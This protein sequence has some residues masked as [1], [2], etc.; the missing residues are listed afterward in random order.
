MANNKRVKRPPKPQRVVE[1]M[2]A[3]P[4]LWAS[5]PDRWP[6]IVT[7]LPD[8][9]EIDMAPASV[10]Y[11]R[12]LRGAAS[13]CFHAAPI[14]VFYQ[15]DRRA[16]QQW[17]SKAQLILDAARGAAMP[18]RWHK[19][20]LRRPPNVTD[21]RRPGYSHMLAFSRRPVPYVP[22]PDVVGPSGMVYEN[23][24]DV[25]ATHL[26]MRWVAGAAAS[27]CDPFCGHGTVLALANQMGMDAFGIDNDPAQ[28]EIARTIVVSVTSAAIDDEAGADTIP[29][30]P[31]PIG[32]ARSEGATDG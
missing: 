32:A 25:A 3:V 27:V 24:M 16:D 30:E 20:V 14:V 9:A 8:A 18:L 13:A 15:T 5:G 2:D 31:T 17:L 10:G 7:S 29:Q 21:L 22:A 23:G 26:A 12:W 11:A 6:A 19:I 28:V 1:C 4:L